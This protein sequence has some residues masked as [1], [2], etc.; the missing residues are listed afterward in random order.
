MCKRSLIYLCLLVLCQT[1]MFA[2][3]VRDSRK[4]AWSLRSMKD[5][6]ALNKRVAELKAGS[7]Q[8]LNLLLEYSFEKKMDP[9]PLI[10]LAMKR[11]PNGEIAFNQGVQK[12]SAEQNLKKKQ[13]LLDSLK[14]RF[15][16]KDYGYVYALLT[17]DFAR[18]GQLNEAM[19]YLKKTSGEDRTTAWYQFA[20]INDPN[21][22]KR[23]ELIIDQ[24]LKRGKQEK[25]ERITL[26]TLKRLFLEKKQDY[27]NAVVL[28]KNIMNLQSDISQYNTDHYH[29]LLSKSGQYHAALAGLK[30][31]LLREIDD[32][33]IK[34]EYKKAYKHVYPGRDA[35]AHLDSIQKA[36][37]LKYEADYKDHITDKLIK[38]KAPAYE[39]L[40]VNGKV[41]S[42]DEFK[43]KMLVIDFW[44]TWCV[45]CKA[46]LPGMQELVNK[47]QA[48]PTIQFLFIHT[49]ETAGNTFATVRDQALGYFREQ[50][51]S[52]P[53]Y[54]DLK[55]K[56]NNENKVAGNFKVNG[57][58]HK[59]IIDRNGFIRFT[60]VG[61]GGSNTELVAEIS[62]VIETIKN[63]NE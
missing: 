28:E 41:V 63:L 10:E 46:S 12:V 32:Q 52:L 5:T 42:S 7:E 47:Y 3:D 1:G 15:P 45:P 14:R 13:N 44:A 26:L 6:A 29:Y 36:V 37:A 34:D 62:A 31:A 23:A 61:F 56:D 18:A 9:S 50:H 48:D 53:L 30:D 38:E 51:F 59:A 2:Q 55:T 49:S 21:I 20:F 19:T 57:I 22:I 24:A 58:P 39:L 60:S 54:I 8:D 43:G 17:G 11:F 25:E 33:E 4:E 40:D 35:Q 27:K 16:Q